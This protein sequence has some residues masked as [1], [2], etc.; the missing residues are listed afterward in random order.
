MKIYK[1]TASDKYGTI[2]KSE[3]TADNTA[4]VMKRLKEKK[5]ALI[6]IKE[7]TKTIK[8]KNVKDNK[9]RREAL[10]HRIGKGQTA[11][12]VNRGKHHS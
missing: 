9:I 12:I 1:Y 2:F 7:Q 8:R 3:M 4:E 6:R 10:T 11:E 5:I